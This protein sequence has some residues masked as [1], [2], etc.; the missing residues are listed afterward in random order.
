VHGIEGIRAALRTLF[1]GAADFANRVDD[2]LGLHPEALVLRITNFGTL[3]VGGGAYERPSV[4]L[5]MFGADG[6][7]THI[8][9][10]DVGHEAEA[11]ARFDELTRAAEPVRSVHRRVQPNAATALIERGEPLMT[12]RDLDAVAALWAD[13]IRYLHGPAGVVLGREEMLAWMRLHFE[14]RGAT[15]HAENIATL[16]DSL[17]LQSATWSGSTS[18]DPDYPV[19]AFERCYFQ[20]CQVDA[21]GRMREGESFAP[22]RLADAIARLYER[23][24]GLIPDGPERV[25]SIANARFVVLFARGPDETLDPDGPSTLAPDIEVVDH[26]TLGTWSVQGREALVQNFRAWRD[27]ADDI[28][29]RA[30]DIL[31]LRAGALLVRWAHTG[32]DRASGGVYERPFLLLWIVGADG[33]MTRWEFFEPDREAEALARFDA[34]TAKAT[35][36]RFANAASRSEERTLAC[37]AARDW[38]GVM[39]SY[40]PALRFDDRRRL[41]RLEIGAEDFVTQYRLLF[42]QPGSRWHEPLLATRG[43]RLSL[44]RVLFQAEAAE[45]GGPLEFEEHL[46]LIEVDG[47]GRQIGLVAFDADDLDGAYAE[48]DARWDAGEATAH[49]RASAWIAAFRRAFASR[50]WEAMAAL[51]APDQV[52]HNYRLVGWGTLR[53]PRAWIP[54]LE[55]LVELAPDVWLRIDHLRT[56][57]RGFLFHYSWQGTREGGEFDTPQLLVVE[58][59]DQGRQR[60]LDVWDCE[61]LDAALTRFAELSGV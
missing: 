39:A 37:W 33:L 15:L 10:F 29:I 13:D 36:P 20:L 52:A 47:E 19:G 46:A 18:V 42:D 48:L 5:W 27:V 55:Q 12:A 45:G 24:A 21:Q 61:A 28:T 40:S 14:D 1:E 34:L 26:R 43:E 49:P 4:M 58:L 11:L 56:C 38:A 57:E 54:P 17:A 60:R 51:H 41:V 44:H 8:E 22:D 16:G 32:T 9:Q 25:Q 30:Q 31:A 59:D 23:H 35:E 3:R 6:L 2:V 7:M 53:G 50:D